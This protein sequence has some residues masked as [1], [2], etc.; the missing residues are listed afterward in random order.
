MTEILS[1]CFT[2]FKIELLSM[3]PEKTLLE[4]LKQNIE[5]NF[6][7]LKI[8]ELIIIASLE[9]QNLITKLLIHQGLRK[10]QHWVLF[11]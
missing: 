9:N 1:F 2:G 6:P 4:R 7:E 11:S 8:G 10:N 3:I 5:P